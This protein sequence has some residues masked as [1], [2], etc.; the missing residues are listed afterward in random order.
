MLY[1][2]IS[3]D[4]EF[5]QLNSQILAWK[6]PENYNIWNDNRFFLGIPQERIL[7]NG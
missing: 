3:T 6:K 5:Q 7:R 2:N 4:I 1:F